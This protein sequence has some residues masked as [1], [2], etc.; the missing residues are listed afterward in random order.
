[1]SGQNLEIC[2]VHSR[3]WRQMVSVRLHLQTRPIVGRLE[4]VVVTSDGKSVC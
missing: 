1:V 4:K 2:E 3:E